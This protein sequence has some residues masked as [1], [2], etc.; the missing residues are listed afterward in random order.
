[1]LKILLKLTCAIT[2]LGLLRR[3]L[4]KVNNLKAKYLHWTLLSLC[5]LPRHPGPDIHEV[6]TQMVTDSTASTFSVAQHTYGSNNSPKEHY[7][8]FKQQMCV[9]AETRSWDAPDRTNLSSLSMLGEGTLDR[10]LPEF[11]HSDPAS[12]P[13]ESSWFSM[14]SSLTHLWQTLCW[15]GR[16]RGCVNSSLQMG[17]ISSRSMF[18]M[19]T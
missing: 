12:V 1:M 11:E 10:G 15:Q 2:D 4:T 8:I 5:F 17:Q 7:F 16:M 6:G 19:G 14:S 3:V 18:L 9:S 13:N